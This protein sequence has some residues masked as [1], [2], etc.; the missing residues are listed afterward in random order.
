MRSEPQMTD[1]SARR[2]SADAEMK[3]TGPAGLFVVT[4][5]TGKT[6]AAE[7]IAND[8]RLP[9]FHIDLSKV[10]SKYIGETEKNLAAIFV[11]AEE[12]SVLLFFDEVDALFSTRTE[13][14]D[15]HDRYANIETSYLLQ[16]I[17]SFDGLAVMACNLEENRRPCN[18]DAPKEDF[19]AH[20][21]YAYVGV[22]KLIREYRTH[23]YRQL[24]SRVRRRRCRSAFRTDP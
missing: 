21:I 4:A 16:R 8:L 22:S 11:D 5:G 14:T 7:L 18:G 13:V 10:I 20:H 17:E 23:R 24:Q 3:L 19:N 6:M 15:A 1:S 12:S 2:F 9:L